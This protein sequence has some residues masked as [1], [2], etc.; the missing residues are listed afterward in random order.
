MSADGE[1]PRFYTRWG[2]APKR[3]APPRV[4]SG[5]GESHLTINAIS[6][7]WGNFEGISHARKIRGA[8]YV[9]MRGGKN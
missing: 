6:I 3:L 7:D 2:D 8:Q 5:G 9:V 1:L 4:K